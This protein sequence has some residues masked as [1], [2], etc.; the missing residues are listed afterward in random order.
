MILEAWNFLNS[1]QEM[2]LMKKNR[3][4]LQV[5]IKFE[6]KHIV[7]INKKLLLLN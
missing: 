3:I 4:N 5:N 2:K 1:K 7:I 6:E